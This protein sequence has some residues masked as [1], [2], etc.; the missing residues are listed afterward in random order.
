MRRFIRGLT[1]E[2]SRRNKQKSALSS[3]VR[4]LVLEIPQQPLDVVQFD[5]RAERVAEAPTQ[6]FENAAR[7]LNIDLTRHLH[8]R[9]V[10]V[11]VP[12]HR[13]S[14][15]IG[16]L[17]SA[18][19]PSAPGLPRPHA[20][21]RLH[22]LSEVLRAAPHGLE[23]APLGVNGGI[24]V[25]VAER[26][27]GVA[28][29]FL[30]ATERSLAPFA[31]RL[32]AQLAALLEFVE[33][34]SQLLAQSLLVLAQAAHSFVLLAL[35][36]LLPLLTLLALLAA[37]PALAFAPRVLALPERTVSQLLLLADHV[38]QFVERRHH[39]VVIAV[40]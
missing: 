23:R 5:L 30:C 19:G 34:L 31:R 3:V 35:L 14:Q 22:L 40:G 24:R 8:G 28:H 36:P 6:F 26:T 32:L 4:R 25:A 33:Q 37:L 21:S 16:V 1:T 20:R 10:T 29:R 17:L 27:L 11:F 15:G 7:A 2:D 39:V 12:A 13:S 38:T 9:I 18:R